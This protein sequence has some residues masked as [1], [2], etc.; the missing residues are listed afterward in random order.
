[1]YFNTYEKV[2][3]GVTA[4]SNFTFDLEMLNFGYVGFQVV[5]TSHNDG[6]ATNVAKLL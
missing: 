1:M 6:N 2:L 4:S 5:W 3:S